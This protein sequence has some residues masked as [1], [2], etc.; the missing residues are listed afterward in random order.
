MGCTA[1][2]KARRILN[3]VERILAIELMAAAQ[4]IDFRREF[5]PPEARLGRGTQPVYDLI[6]EHVPF[7]DE[8]TILYRYMEAVRQ[9][10]RQGSVVRA[11]GT[12]RG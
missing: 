8:D 7:I 6:R 12:L 9:L 11:V 3:N 5:V 4:G 1:A 2:L 10:V